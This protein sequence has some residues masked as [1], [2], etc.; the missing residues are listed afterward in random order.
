MPAIDRAYPRWF[1]TYN[2]R[3]NASANCKIWEAARATTAA[4]TFFKRIAIGETGQIKEQFIDAGIRCNN[5]TKEI[6]EEA[7]LLFGDDRPIGSLVSIGTGH[8]GTV[9]LPEPD[10]FQ[11]ILPTKLIPVLKNIATDCESTADDL[12]RRFANLPDLYF[13]YNVTHGAG[14]ISLEE[15]KK[16][17]DVQTHT[18]A[19]L[20]ELQVSKSINSLVK[21]LCLVKS[22]HRLSDRRATLADMCMS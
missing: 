10:A 5:P 11:K 16:M 4:P 14:M 8:P 21:L 2:V 19:Y 3:S 7:R 13:R 22:S 20:N 12:A 15:W 1:R 17:G 6:M 9:G 18:Y